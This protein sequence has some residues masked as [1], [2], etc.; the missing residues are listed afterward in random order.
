MKPQQTLPVMETFY[1]V[2]GEGFHTGKPAF[3]IRLA[4]CRVG[5]TWC[6]VKES[7]DAGNHPKRTIHEIVGDA[8][9]SG[10]ANIVITGGEPLEH[11]L[12]LLTTALKD[13][14]FK[15][16]LETSGTS[17]LSGAFDYICLSPKKFLPS[18]P[19]I[20]ALADEL[21]VVVYHPTDLI[22]GIEQAKTVGK[23]CHLIF[24]PEWDMREKMIPLILS[25]IRENP[26]WRIGLQ[27]HKW[28][29]V[30]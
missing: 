24:Q 6:D 17:P 2:Q 13:K 27:T 11:D 29:G 7:W 14:G 30:R 25:F 28:M 9:A 22:W 23:D 26:A 12:S 5:C 15:V 20:K 4:G 18:L 1:S 19:E 8:E 10:A 16:W 21:K 3:F